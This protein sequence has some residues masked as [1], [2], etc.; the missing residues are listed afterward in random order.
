M[1]TIGRIRSF[2]PTAA[3]L[4]NSKDEYLSDIKARRQEEAA[5]RKDREVGLAPATNSISCTP[6]LQP[7]TTTAA[8]LKSYRLCYREAGSVCLSLFGLAQPHV[9]TSL[10]AK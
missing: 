6:L 10:F 7:S 9:I 2:A 1:A 5:A 8:V 3:K 4:A